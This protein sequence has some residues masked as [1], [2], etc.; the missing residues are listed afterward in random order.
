M[1]I[2]KTIAQRT[3]MNVPPDLR[4]PEQYTLAARPI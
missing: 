1:K 2:G 4:S 3:A